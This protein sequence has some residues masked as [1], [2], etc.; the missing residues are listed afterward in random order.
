MRTRVALLVAA[1]GLF[2]LSAAA[3]APARTVARL[4]RSAL[5]PNAVA[6]RD[7]LYG[8][9]GTQGTISA[10]SDGGK[11][12]HVV[13]R[14]RSPVVAVAFFHDAFYAKLEDGQTLS[15]SGRHWRDQAAV[16]FRGHC[17]QGWHPGFTADI[18]ETDLGRP[19]S[20]C[21]GEPGAG[22]VAKAVYRGR[23]RVAYTP[24]AAHGGYG[25]ISVYGYPVGIAGSYG[26]FALIWE[27]R[28][29]LYVTRNGGH[30]WHALPKIAR[31]EVD[32]ADWADVNPGNGTAFVLLQYSLGA[33][34]AH[35]LIET[36]DAGHTWHVVH[37][38]R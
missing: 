6:F 7:R 28:G 3:G 27:S 11:T 2:S 23:K 9:L 18:L 19:W 35:R 29:T 31:P 5:V 14:T 8:V 33:G 37:R 26:G 16:L 15:G 32:F 38:W 21:S 13:H 10:T 36:T 24:F 17:P 12:W 22:N 25:G 34:E 20:V 1:V 4:P 30:H